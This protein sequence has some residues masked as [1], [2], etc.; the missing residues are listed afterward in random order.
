MAVPVYLCCI[1][2][3]VLLSSCTSLGGRPASYGPTIAAVERDSQAQAP[4]AGRSQ[5]D[6]SVIV[7]PI[8]TFSRGR[9]VPGSVFDGTGALDT[10]HPMPPKARLQYWEWIRQETFRGIYASSVEVDDARVVRLEGD[11][12]Q[13]LYCLAASTSRAGLAEQEYVPVWNH[14]EALEEPEPILSEK[15]R[16]NLLS[17]EEAARARALSSG[18]TSAGTLTESGPVTVELL[19]LSSSDE[20]ALVW[21]HVTRRPEYGRDSSM[22]DQQVGSDYYA[23]LRTT[24]NEEEVATCEGIWERLESSNEEGS[25]GTD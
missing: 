20:E 10:A 12:R 15:L 18:T 4:G 17:L 25:L 3:L 16:A 23:L 13:N 9:W 5:L 24:P 7:H 1:V 8:A 2:L 6:R 14:A 11:A 22:Q 21:A 19:R